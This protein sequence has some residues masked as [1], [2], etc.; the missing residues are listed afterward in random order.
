LK[1]QRFIYIVASQEK[2]GTLK[3]GPRWEAKGTEEYVVDCFPSTTS[4]PKLFTFNTGW[5]TQRVPYQTNVSQ[6]ANENS[7]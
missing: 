5:Q 2:Y 4:H 6:S 7:I 1:A 3:N